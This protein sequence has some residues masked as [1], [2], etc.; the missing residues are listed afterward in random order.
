ME[1]ACQLNAEDANATY[2]SD[3]SGSGQWLCRALTSMMLLEAASAFF[4]CFADWDFSGFV[5]AYGRVRR[6]PLPGIRLLRRALSCGSGA[7]TCNC[8]TGFGHDHVRAI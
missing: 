1:V 6:M 2:P 3:T 8:G 4:G 7:S 5:Y